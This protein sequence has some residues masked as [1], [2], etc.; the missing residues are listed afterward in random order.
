MMMVP[1]SVILFV[2]STSKLSVSVSVDPQVAAFGNV[3]HI[4]SGEALQTSDV[5]VVRRDNHS[6]VGRVVDGKTAAY[7]SLNVV[8]IADVGTGLRADK[9]LAVDAHIDAVVVAVCNDGSAGH[10]PGT[11][12]NNVE[13]STGPGSSRLGRCTN[14]CVG[15]V[16]A[17]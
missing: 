4:T 12:I 14:S 16:P 6:R 2:V 13:S 15:E 5:A 7:F 11:E 17:T 1:V 10:G 8:D 3:L 9:E